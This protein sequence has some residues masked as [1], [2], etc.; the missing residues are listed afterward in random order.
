MGVGGGTGGPLTS[1][2]GLNQDLGRLPTHLQDVPPSRAFL[3]HVLPQ[4]LGTPHS[5]NSGLSP[6]VITSWHRWWV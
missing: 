4:H 1:P 6:A 2:T 3:D 5:P